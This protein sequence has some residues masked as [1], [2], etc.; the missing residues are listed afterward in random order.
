MLHLERPS[1]AAHFV[2]DKPS[3]SFFL[4][5]LQDFD[6]RFGFAGFLL[7]NTIL[8]GTCVGCIHTRLGHKKMGVDAEVLIFGPFREVIETGKE[9]VANADGASGDDVELATI[10]L[11]A[12][13]GVVKEGERALK[14]LKPLWDEQV[15]KYGEAF[16][17]GLTQDGTFSPFRPWSG[18]TH[19]LTCSRGHRGQEE[20]TGGPPL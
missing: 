3:V 4:P 10:M 19:M 16:K 7:K 13:Q 12:A 8:V 20:K 17:N 9:A 14:R 6:F 15:D 5:W 11:K 1:S 18:D 2:R